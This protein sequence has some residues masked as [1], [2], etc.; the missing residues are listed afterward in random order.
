MSNQTAIKTL[1]ALRAAEV[2]EAARETSHYALG[3]KWLP[4]ILASFKNA[5]KNADARFTAT[6]AVARKHGVTWCTYRNIP[7]VVRDS[8][9]L[10]EDEEDWG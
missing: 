3:A 8:T 6:L 10:R 5:E 9:P 4:A 1:L 7:V 2:V